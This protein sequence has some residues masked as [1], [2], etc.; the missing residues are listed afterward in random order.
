MKA[1]KCLWQLNQSVEAINWLNRAIKAD[2]KLIEAY[3]LQ[4]DYY[5]QRYNYQTALQVLNKASRIFP[6]NS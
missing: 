6:N 2:A 4:P 5:S 1:G 3:V